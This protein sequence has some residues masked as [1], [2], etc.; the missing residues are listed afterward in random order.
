M[1]NSRTVLL[2]EVKGTSNVDNLE[3]EH[4]SPL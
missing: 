2:R 3:A 4:K 1:V